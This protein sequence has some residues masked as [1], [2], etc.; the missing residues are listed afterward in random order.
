MNV[1]AG[2]GDESRTAKKEGLKS[3]SDLPT[4]LEQSTTITQQQQQPTTMTDANNN[5]HQSNYQTTFSLN[6]FQLETLIVRLKDHLSKKSKRIAQPQT[7]PSPPLPA[8]IDFKL[9]QQTDANLHQNLPLLKVPLFFA[10]IL[11]SLF[12]NLDSYF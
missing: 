10:L 3:S 7:T 5:H 12:L 4:G 11:Q 9:I 2:G 8:S 6:S 1:T